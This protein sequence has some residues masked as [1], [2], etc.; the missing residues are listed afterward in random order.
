MA[1]R[2]FILVLV[3]SVCLWACRTANVGPN[4]AK[5]N[6]R[7]SKIVENV[8]ANTPTYTKASYKFSCEYSV[9]GGTPD[10]FSG[11]LRVCRDS[12]MWISLR[13]FNIEGFRV[14]ISKDS[15][16]VMNRLK[17]EYYAEDISALESIAKLEMSYNDLQSILLNE[18]F[19][20]PSDG[21]TIKDYDDYDYKSCVDTVYYCISTISQKKLNKIA[22]RSNSNY[23]ERHG[24]VIQTVKVV[25]GTFKVKNMYLED[26][27]TGRNAFVEYGKFARFGEL[28]FPQTMNIYVESG[29]FNG[30]MKFTISDFEVNDEL[31]YPFKVPA[32]YTKIELNEKNR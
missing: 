28:L 11:N 23:A 26:L 8:M 17:N 12:L 29:D 19:R 9:N 20:Y 6:I 18:F 4:E 24:S 30:R 31:T 16:R 10:S 22:E 13:S 7:S 2:N 32:K 1:K 3:L 27:E 15:V 5:D 25:P 14:L 21:T